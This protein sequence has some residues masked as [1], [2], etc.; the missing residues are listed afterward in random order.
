[1][2]ILKKKVLEGACN[3]DRNDNYYATIEKAHRKV[4]VVKLEH[5]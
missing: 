2:T 4:F 1:M 5:K 3:V